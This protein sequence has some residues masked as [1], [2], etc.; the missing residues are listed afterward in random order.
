VWLLSLFWLLQAFGTVG[1]TLFLP[2]IIKTMSGTGDFVTSLLAALPFVVACAFML[3]NSR[4][5]DATRE[6]RLHLALPMFAAG[7]LLAIAV[8]I[9]DTRV[10]YVLLVFTVA[11]NWAATPVFWATT[12]EYLAGGA[13]AAAAIALINAIA[14]LA[15]VGLP[16]FMGQLWD[17]SGTYSGGLLLISVAL[18]LGGVIACLLKRHSPTAAVS[19]HESPV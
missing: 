14:N 19:A 8:G 1:I 9:E 15:G 5:S 16:P 7:L 13:A 3:L 18:L 11:L 17:K 12:T 2:Q 6:R 10:A 4:H